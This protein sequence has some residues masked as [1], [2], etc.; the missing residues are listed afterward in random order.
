MTDKQCVLMRHGIYYIKNKLV[1]PCCYNSSG[2]I[3]Q[4][5]TIDPIF[6][7][8]CIAE[9]DRGIQ[10]YRQGSNIK[11]GLTHAKNSILSLEITPNMNCNLTCKICSELSSTS[12]AK[13][14]NIKINQTVNLKSNELKKLLETYD[15][16]NLQEINF[17]GGEPFL[18]NNIVNYMDMVATMVD[19]STVTL[20][21]STNG[22][23]KLTDKI[24]NCLS[25]FKLVTARFS[26][27]DIEE[28]HE[29]HR[30]PA[31]WKEW[32]ENWEFFLK[33]MPNNT[34]PSINRTVGILNLNRLQLLNQW[35]QSY[36]TTKLGDPIELL[37]HFAYGETA[38]D[39]VPSTVK[40]F[41]LLI[42]G[43]NS[44]NW[45]YIKNSEIISDYADTLSYISQL[46]QY[47]NQSFKQ[48]DA[49]MHRILFTAPS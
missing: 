28:G 11:F 5:Y 15:F 49:E 6:C 27:D 4:D 16:S 24:F 17:S 12:W 32:Q 18:N 34:I 39:K 9:E 1:G 14:K 22:S 40:D 41:I 19:L 23:I 46:D 42:H 33:T 30:Y 13:L 45:Q 31:K 44:I 26:L 48:Y 25:K 8:K 20:R 36:L 2:K 37:D 43:E 10:S 38:I 47:H 3:S 35:H 7:K 29:Y 21:F